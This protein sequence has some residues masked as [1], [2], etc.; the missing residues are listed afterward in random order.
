[1]YSF[2]ARQP[3]LNQRKQVVAYELLF[4]DSAEN[5]FPNIDSDDA[6]RTLVSNSFLNVGFENIADNKT[7]YINFS[8]QA[9]L[10]QLPRMLP[11]EKVVIELLEDIQPT[12]ELLEEVK[13]LHKL[14]Y[15]LALDD[16]EY[17]S[18][19]QRFFRYIDIIK[20][21]LRA[22]SFADI[23][24][25]IGFSRHH[26]IQYLAE[27]VETHE[28]FEQ[29]SRLGINL[30]QGYFFSRPELLKH[31]ALSPS[32]LVVLELLSEINK[33][34]INFNQIEDI[35]AHDVSLSYKLLMFVNKQIKSDAKPIASFKQASIYLG[36]ERLRKFISLVATSLSSKDKPSELY[37]MSVI[38]AR[39]CERIIGESSLSC[40]PDEAF[41]TGLFSLLDSLLDQPMNLLIEQIQLDDRVKD[42]LLQRKGPL[43]LCLGSIE[44]FEMGLWQKIDDDA[45]QL[46]T[47]PEK[48]AQVYLESLAWAKAFSLTTT[49]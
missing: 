19:W 42:A 1:M 4:R 45:V 9:V 2:V 27:K 21:D 30:F 33:P 49:K 17:T 37:V 16:F 10:Q 18:D 14:G 25:V 22:T 31:R 11:K 36:E 6:T 29:A 48:I 46:H 20:F 15:T 24:S 34:N 23:R 43:A 38:R 28:E 8:Y 26:N 44:H 40:S 3:I 35:F 47:T 5:I 13:A 32:Q 39:F 12:E 7:C 41:I